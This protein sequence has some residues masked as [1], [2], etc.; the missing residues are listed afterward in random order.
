LRGA[1]LKEQIE[2]A[3]QR[4]KDAGAPAGS[5]RQRAMVEQELLHLGWYKEWALIEAGRRLGMMADIARGDSPLK[6]KEAPKP[7]PFETKIAPR[8]TRQAE[9]E[10]SWKR[11]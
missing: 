8:F 10:F 5:E 2:L 3:R 11:R 6:V 9:R 1:R 7:L 4:A